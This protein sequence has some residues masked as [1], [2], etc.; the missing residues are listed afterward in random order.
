M[1]F[2]V[3]AVPF[4]PNVR[5]EEEAASVYLFPLRGRFTP[6]LQLVAPQRLIAQARC[7]RLEKNQRLDIRLT[8]RDCVEFFLDEDSLTTYGRLSFGV[9]GAIAFVPGP[10]YDFDRGTSA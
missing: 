6:L 2:P 10:D 3:K 7:I 9:A 8:D 1:N 5:V 4:K